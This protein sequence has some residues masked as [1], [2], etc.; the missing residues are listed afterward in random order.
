MY[1]VGSPAHDFG[2]GC[3]TKMLATELFGYQ[4]SAES[5]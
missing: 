5:C 1:G 3:D 2:K 4:Q